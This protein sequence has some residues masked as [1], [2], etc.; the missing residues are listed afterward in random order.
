MGSFF[1]TVF[2]PVKSKMLGP[3]EISDL[4]LTVFHFIGFRI[5]MKSGWDADLNEANKLET[6][7]LEEKT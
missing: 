2:V 4:L 1:L 7:P 5:P 6:F 3:L